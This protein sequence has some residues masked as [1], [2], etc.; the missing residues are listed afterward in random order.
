M[1]DPN[2][3]GMATGQTATIPVLEPIAKLT[4]TA[5]KLKEREAK[6][7][8]EQEQL[9][10]RNEAAKTSVFTSHANISVAQFQHGEKRVKTGL[11]AR[12][13][14]ATRFGEYMFGTARPEFT[15]QN[16]RVQLSQHTGEQVISRLGQEYN[17]AVQ[18]LNSYQDAM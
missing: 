7:W 2:L 12:E 11:A 9:H 10:G 3:K 17:Q 18:D 6:D 5:V 1:P 4:E 8:K 16:Y 14:G 13:K 15:S